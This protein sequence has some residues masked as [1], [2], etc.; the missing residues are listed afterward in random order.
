MLHLAVSVHRDGSAALHKPPAPST[1]AY[2]GLQTGL[3]SD[4]GS[5]AACHLVRH[6][7]RPRIDDEVSLTWLPELSQATLIC[8]VRE[9][10]TCLRAAGEA[11]DGEIAPVI[12]S[13][14]R[15]ALQHAQRAIAGRAAIVAELLGTSRPSELAQALSRMSAPSY[16]QRHKLLGGVRVLPVGRF[17]VG[18][19]DFYPAIV[20][21]WRSSAKPESSSTLSRSAA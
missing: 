11:F 6:L 16:D 9:V 12:P 2:C 21:S 4:D 15:V 13:P 19:D 10:H 20:D 5:C 7:D 1:C 8:L 17:F 3:H 18:S 14:E